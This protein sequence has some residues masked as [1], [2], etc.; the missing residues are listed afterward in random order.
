V[1]LVEM[2]ALIAERGDRTDAEMPVEFKQRVFSVL[3]KDHAKA[4][5]FIFDLENDLEEAMETGDFE[6]FRKKQVLLTSMELLEAELRG[7][8]DLLMQEIEAAT[9]PSETATDLSELWARVK[10][11][12]AAQPS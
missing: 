3:A 4:L 9:P 11:R 7:L 12:E 1:S 5:F 6:M 10:A 8:M 2:Q